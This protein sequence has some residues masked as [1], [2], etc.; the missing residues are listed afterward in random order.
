[1][2]CLR[3]A[4][5]E[6]PVSIKAQVISAERPRKP[7]LLVDDVHILMGSGDLALPILD[8]FKSDANEIETAPTV[9]STQQT[10]K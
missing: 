1:M 9:Y 4:S 6:P 2:L 3:W 8:K 10:R 5:G 7:Y